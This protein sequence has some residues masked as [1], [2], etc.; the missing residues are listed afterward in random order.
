MCYFPRCS[1]SR[2]TDCCPGCSPSRYHR[3]SL[4]RSTRC[5][6]GSSDHC[7]LSRRPLCPPRSSDRCGPDCSVSCFPSCP[8]SCSAHCL[9]VCRAGNVPDQTLWRATERPYPNHSIGLA[10][11]GPGFTTGRAD[12]RP[13]AGGCL[14]T[15]GAQFPLSP[16]RLP[17]RRQPCCRTPRQ[18]AL[19]DDPTDS[20]LEACDLGLALP[21]ATS[22]VRGP[23][24]PW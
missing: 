13:L 24:W 23:A 3:C 19:H 7:G 6:T 8:P 11:P 15:A 14:W 12:R 1:Q 17:E 5:S 21:P 10:P 22:V 18:P 16:A 20:L 2:F 4:H 9:P